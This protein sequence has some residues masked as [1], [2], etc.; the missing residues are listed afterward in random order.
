MLEYFGYSDQNWDRCYDTILRGMLASH[1]GLVIFPVQDLL[2]Y[3]NDT[4]INIPGK[5]E[6][7]WTFRIT[8]EQLNTVD[9]QKFRKWNEMYGRI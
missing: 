1:G 9:M 5:S 3:G 8:R 7:N 6:G 4:R 2:L